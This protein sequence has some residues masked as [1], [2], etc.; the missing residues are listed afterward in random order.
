MRQSKHF[1]QQYF[2]VF[3]R[4]VKLHLINA[5]AGV[6]CDANMEVM[7]EAEQVPLN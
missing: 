1:F 3:F 2:I 6:A 7:V 4:Q 5:G